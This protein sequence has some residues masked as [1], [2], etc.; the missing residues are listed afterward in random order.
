MAIHACRISKLYAFRHRDILHAAHKMQQPFLLYRKLR[1]CS[2]KKEQ[3]FTERMS[4]KFLF[5][6]KVR[7]KKQKS[8]TRMRTQ[9][10]LPRRI[11]GAESRRRDS[12]RLPPYCCAGLVQPASPLK[13]CFAVLA[14]VNLFFLVCQHKYLVK[15][16]FNRSDAPRVFA[17]DYILDFLW[18]GKHPFFHD[19]II[20][21]NIHRNVMVDKTKNIQ[22]QGINR[23]FYFNDILFAHF[24][25]FC[26]FNNC[27]AA[28]QP[29]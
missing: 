4:D 8:F 5:H 23:A 15:P 13:F 27:D 1:I 6:G 20:F 21:N 25:A 16:L 28:V 2:N 14:P 17:P 26:I 3:E 29:V 10:P 11:C 12:Y 22:I 9:M 18:K 19:F 7:P 24:A